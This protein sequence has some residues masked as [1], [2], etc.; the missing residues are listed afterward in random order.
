MFRRP[1]VIVT[2]GVFASVMLL[3][4][5]CS[6]I[7]PEGNHPSSETPCRDGC[8]SDVWPRLILGVIPPAG[9][10]KDGSELVRARIR[11]TDGS[12]F[13]GNIHGCPNVDGIFFDPNLQR[14]TSA[15]GILCTYSFFALP[16]DV[17]VVL[18]VEP[19]SFMSSPVEAEIPLGRFNY[20]GR[21][22]AYT[23]ATVT[24]E[25]QISI[26]TPRLVSPCEELQ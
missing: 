23:V 15:R 2:L 24:S 20:C 6:Q 12:V 4:L 26:G 10:T 3:L 13:D 5:A 22:I 17:S 25:G 18:L 14:Y 21:E 11:T 9:S 8:E 19:V 7:G 1:A 16:K